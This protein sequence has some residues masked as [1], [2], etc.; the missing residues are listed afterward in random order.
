MIV[1]FALFSISMDGVGAR[2]RH[3]L[4]RHGCIQGGFCLAFSARLDRRSK[5]I[6]T[7]ST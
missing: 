4:V 5:A 7:S 3:G 2:E 6:H 1:A